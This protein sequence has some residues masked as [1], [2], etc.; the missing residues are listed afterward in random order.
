MYKTHV[1]VVIN[2]RTHAR[3]FTSTQ[4]TL[5]GVL[6]DAD[7]LGRS[8]GAGQPVLQVHGIIQCWQWVRIL[9]H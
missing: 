7:G 1:T 5:D 3:A 6:Y 9:L 4:L 2:V 8:L